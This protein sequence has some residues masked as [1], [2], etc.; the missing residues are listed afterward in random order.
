[1]QLLHSPSHERLSE[2]VARGACK[3]LEALTLMQSSKA[4]TIEY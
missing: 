2:E 1:M 3:A 4:C